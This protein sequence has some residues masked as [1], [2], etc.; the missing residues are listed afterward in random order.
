[1]IQQGIYL[2]ENGFQENADR[3]ELLRVRMST[4]GNTAMLKF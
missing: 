3:A 4:S 2:R 1:M